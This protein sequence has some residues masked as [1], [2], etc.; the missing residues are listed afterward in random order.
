MYVSKWSWLIYFSS[1]TLLVILLIDSVSIDFFL[2]QK[3]KGREGANTYWVSTMGK[4][5]S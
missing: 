2:I 4:A 3:K 1:P 5:L